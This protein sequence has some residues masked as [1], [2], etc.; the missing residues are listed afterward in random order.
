M[1]TLAELL[2]T[3]AE[4]KGTEADADAAVTLARGVVARTPADGREDE[5]IAGSRAMRLVNLAAALTTRATHFPGLPGARADLDEAIAAGRAAVSLPASIAQAAPAVARATMIALANLAAA[6]SARAGLADAGGAAIERDA[7]RADLDAAVEF[8]VAALTATDPALAMPGSGPVTRSLALSSLGRA[9]SRR[10]ALFADPSDLARFIACGEEAAGMTDAP[11]RTRVRAAILGGRPAASEDPARGARCWRPRSGSSPSWRPGTS[12]AVT[13]SRCSARSPGWR[14]TRRRRSSP[15]S[16]A[17]PRTRGPRAPWDCS[18]RAAGSC[19][20]AASTCAATWPHWSVRPA[21][22]SRFAWLRAMLDADGPAL[23]SSTASGPGLGPPDELADPTEEDRLLL[24]EELET[25]LASI[26]SRDRFAFFGLPPDGATLGTASSEGAVVVCTVTLTSGHAL[27]VT[28]GR[29]TA[30]PLPGLT[31]YTLNDQA[32]IFYLALEET[33]AN[34]LATVEGIPK[35]LEWLWDTV[36]GPVLEFLEVTAAPAGGAP[37]PRIWWA[38]GGLLGRLPVHAAGY[39]GDPPAPAKRTVMDRAVIS[40]IPTIRALLH[41]RDRRDRARVSAAAA[42][43]A[44][45]TEPAALSSLIVAMPQTPGLPAAT[46]PGALDE[47]TAVAPAAPPI[48]S[49]WP[50][51][52]PNPN[53]TPSRQLPGTR[54]RRRPNRSSLPS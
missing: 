47:A 53:P 45:V 51:P 33:M 21:L 44:A 8:G 1:G 24:A 48:P 4:R 34:P 16:R 18:R 30:L 25:V 32:R 41:A 10:F 28:G 36:T 50:N 42:I 43:G 17:G 46:L 6:L 12:P 13:S 11:A 5:T 52:N 35:V 29:V 40:Y 26:R 9:L 14:A 20:A 3:R 7:A 31:A 27:I 38:P 15:T 54:E 23:P 2:R 39:H 49:S 22:A 37:L 19:L